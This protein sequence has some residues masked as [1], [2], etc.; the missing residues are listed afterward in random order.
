M[1]A[2]LAALGILAFA[3]IAP[4]AEPWRDIY[5]CGKSAGH[6][7]IMDGT[8]W[9]EDGIANGIIVLRRRGEEFDLLIGDSSGSSFSAR[10]DGAKIF[11]RED[12]GAFQ[13]V[14]VYPALAVETYLFA[15]PAKGRASL[16][17]TSSKRSGIAD[18]VSAFVSSCISWKG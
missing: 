16:A 17:W 13:V 5:S 11:G 9:T 7:Y 10:D 12:G 3:N 4:A 2:A 15:A 18:R 1:T 14:V 8:G 6:S